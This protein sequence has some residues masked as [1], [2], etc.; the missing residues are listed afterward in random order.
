MVNPYV[1]EIFTF[2]LEREVDFLINLYF[3]K[4]TESFL[5]LQAEVN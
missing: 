3:K 4:P 2:L 1:K 5:N